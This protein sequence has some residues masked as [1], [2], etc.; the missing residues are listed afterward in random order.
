[1]ASPSDRR[2][3]VAI[4]ADSAASLPKD[5]HRHPLL[6]VVPM[7][8][9][10]GHQ[11]F[12]DGVDLDADGFY[13]KL[14]RS[15]ALPTTAAPSPASYVQA[16]REAARR[17]SSVLCLTVASTFSSSYDSARVAIDEVRE[18]EPGLTVDLVDSQTAAGGEGLVVLEALREAEEGG[19]LREVRDAAQ[20]AMRRVTVIAFVDTLYY[21][22]KG[23][24]V[25]RIAHAATSLLQ[26]KPVFELTHGEVRTVARPRTTKRAMRRIVDMMH[27]RATPGRRLHAM[28]IHADAKE[29][30]GQ[31][32]GLIEADFRLERLSVSEFTPV[33]G[34]HVGPG[35]LGVAFW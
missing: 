23:G 20:G 14:R 2:D 9:T 12:E 4:V 18:F 15:R 7:R 21:L 33:M 10:F 1:M 30:A 8:V 34:A 24:R 6:R 29:Q 11:S 16:F 13:R 25:P 31:L 3:R 26:I 22:W 28:V 17:T 32:R 19:D 5:A 35:M 27:R